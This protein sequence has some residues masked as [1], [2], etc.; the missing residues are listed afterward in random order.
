[1]VIFSVIAFPR[2]NN[3]ELTTFYNRPFVLPLAVTQEP[4]MS[5]K[6]QDIAHHTEY[7]VLQL[8]DFIPIFY[9]SP[10]EF[11]VTVKPKKE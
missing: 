2:C 1:M 10:R 9:Q 6:H 8:L 4:S 11:I 3:D 7:D 5:T